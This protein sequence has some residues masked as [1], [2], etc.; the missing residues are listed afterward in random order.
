EPAAD[1]LVVVV[2]GDRKPALRFVL[3][4]DVLVERLFDLPRGRERSWR[5]RRFL[6]LF[7]REYLVAQRDTLVAD[8]HG[9]A[10]D[11]PLDRVL[12][13]S[14]EGTAEMLVARHRLQPPIGD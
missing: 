7:L 11:E 12:G 6:L 2:D 8:V 9:R 4:N 14:A 1:P 3:P 10:R 13:L 5:A